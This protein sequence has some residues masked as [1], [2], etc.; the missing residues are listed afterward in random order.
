MF[1]LITS[2]FK[3]IVSNLCSCWFSL[4]S[5]PFLVCSANELSIFLG[6]LYMGILYMWN[7]GGFL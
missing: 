4:L 1:H 6:A 2:L 7:E 5:S 3:V